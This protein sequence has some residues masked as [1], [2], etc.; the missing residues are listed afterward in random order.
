MARRTFLKEK[1]G[2]QSEPQG[3]D[4]L[5]RNGY[6]ISLDAR[7]TVYP[8]G[9][10]A[11]SGNSIVAVGP[12]REVA[13]KFRPR[14]VLDAGGATVH[15]GFIDAHYH[16]TIHLARG[17][18]S[19][20]PKTKNAI[21]YYD[22]FNAI[23]DEDEYVSALASC[24]EMVHHG[25]TAFMEPGTAFEPDTVA[26]AA[27]DVGI[28]A[29]LADP[30]LWDLKESETVL[31]AGL[32]RAPCHS[33]R[34]RVLLGK[35]LW[36]NKNPSALIR[37]HIC[38]YGLGS[39]SEELLTA[40]KACADENKVVLNLHHN[41][42]REE[43][44][45]NDAFFGG[46]H[47]LVHFRDIGLLDKNCTF[48]HMN[49]VREDEVQPIIDSGMSIVWI[50]GN[51]QFYGIASK[52]RT[53]TP[54][55]IEKGTNVTFGLDSAKVWAFG[56]MEFVGYLIARHWDDYIS[57]EKLL[58]MRTIGAA[59]ALGLEHLVGSLEPGKRADVVI[60]TNNVPEAQPGANV[61]QEMMLVSRSK[62]VGTVIVDG[63]IVFKNGHSTRIEEA[64]VYELARATTKRVMDTIGFSPKI[65]W[66]IVL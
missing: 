12:E 46:G 18:I 29:S 24:V 44:E 60:R 11:I 56:D 61:V 35:E 41:F 55:L 10:L 23:G 22:W 13:P 17:V 50:P 40:A 4:I 54:E 26:A 59:R 21:S 33:K 37:A 66:P 1:T 27:E 16:T 5:I 28:R 19:D 65:S 57:P 34:T 58:E 64:T 14:R 52:V 39:A 31:A 8:S 43:A 45:K 3:C 9:A 30:F 38:L 7:R 20:N 47:S 6:I 15:P 36:R 25:Y 51:Y 63:Q 62:S 53:R 32:K 42:T 2:A 48:S 49:V